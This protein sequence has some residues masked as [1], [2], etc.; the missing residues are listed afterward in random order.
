MRPL[1]IHSS[2]CPGNPLAFWILSHQRSTPH[3][4][5]SVSASLWPAPVFS[6]LPLG[7]LLTSL[8]PR[9]RPWFMVHPPTKLPP[10]PPK[11]CFPRPS[12][13]HLHPDISRKSLFQVLL[14]LSSAPPSGCAK[15]STLSNTKFLPPSPKPTS[16]PHI[17]HPVHV[18]PCTDPARTRGF[19]P[20]AFLLALLPLNQ[21]PTLLC[22]PS[23][24]FFTVSA[25]LSL[26]RLPSVACGPTRHSEKL[27]VS[28]GFYSSSWLPGPAGSETLRG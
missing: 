27:G 22:F 18:T 5:P 2:G 16:P 14:V 17:P 1:L 11:A 19:F 4:C 15:Y 26:P 3:S 8:H 9:L 24:M 7:D 12:N 10:L 20:T 13:P 6:S 28:T 21:S 23:K 25:S